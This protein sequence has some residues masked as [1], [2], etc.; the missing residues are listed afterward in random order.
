MI[1]PQRKNVCTD[2]MDVIFI[3]Q[4]NLPIQLPALQRI[5]LILAQHYVSSSVRISDN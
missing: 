5:L 2:A 4:E 3:S 1:G